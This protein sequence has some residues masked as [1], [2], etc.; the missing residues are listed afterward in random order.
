MILGKSSL[1]RR[2]NDGL[3]NH[4]DPRCIKNCSY[5]VSESVN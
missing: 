4:Y 2:I 5:K 1:I 3:I